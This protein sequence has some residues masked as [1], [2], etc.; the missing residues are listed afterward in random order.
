MKSFYFVPFFVFLSSLC[1][2][3]N[4]NNIESVEYDASQNRFLVSNGTSIIQRASDGTLSYF[5]SGSANYGMEVMNGTLFAI[6]GSNIKGFDL[7]T[8]AEVMNLS[9][10]NT[11][12]LNGLTN[13]GNGRLW[14]T[15]FGANRIYE[16]DVTDI[17]N[18]SSSIVVNSTG[19]TPNGIVYDGINDRLIFVTWSSNADIKAVSL[20]DY[21]VSTVTSTS[22]GSID[23]IDEDNDG[24]YYISY[25]STPAG[26]SKYPADFSTP[27]TIS[28]PGISTP[29]DICYA[30]EIDSLAIPSG[31]NNV[32]FVGFDTSTP[33][34]EIIDE[35]YQFSMGPNPM[36]TETTIQFHLETQEKVNLGIYS[37]DGKL[38]KNLSNGEMTQGWHKVMLTGIE[39]SAG[40]YI[41]NLETKKG[42]I[43]EKLVVR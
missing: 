7:E 41:I 6:S 21:S 5:G 28:V 40:T 24:N 4:Y 10:P 9:I 30:K 39:L 43:T 13:D 3:Q 36:A 20:N 35:D 1:F 14:A 25:W 16:I 31:G 12:F 11:G 8:E 33:V 17:S 37:L 27:T 2:A 42:V 19:A 15:D 22:Y 34:G 26:I 18:P 38:V 23:G 29:A 32:I